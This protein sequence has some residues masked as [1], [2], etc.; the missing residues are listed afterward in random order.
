M[1]TELL[2]DTIYDVSLQPTTRTPAISLPKPPTMLSDMLS[3]DMKQTA[4][5]YAKMDGL[6]TEAYLV[7]LVLKDEY[8]RRI[9]SLY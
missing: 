9:A 8:E 7:K 6:T 1:D 2:Y 3:D 4:A 5:R